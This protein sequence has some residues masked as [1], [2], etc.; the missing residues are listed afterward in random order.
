MPEWIIARGAKVERVR[1]EAPPPNGPKVEQRIRSA[2]TFRDKSMLLPYSEKRAFPGETFLSSLLTIAENNSSER[3]KEKKESDFSSAHSPA[4]LLTFLV[5]VVFTLS[6]KYLEKATSSGK[7]LISRNA[8]APY[9]NIIESS[10]MPGDKMR[11]IAS[12]REN[13]WDKVWNKIV[14]W[15]LLFRAPEIE[16]ATSDNRKGSVV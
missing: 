14:L 8:C 5:I 15:E 4:R 10:N 7:W 13:T 3:W 16:I 11:F 1:P 9:D 2:S 12:T 6:A